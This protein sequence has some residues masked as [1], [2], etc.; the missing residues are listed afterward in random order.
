MCC[1]IVWTVHN[2]VVYIQVKAI[3]TSNYSYVNELNYIYLV[4]E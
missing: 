1:K 2:N 4:A 3:Q